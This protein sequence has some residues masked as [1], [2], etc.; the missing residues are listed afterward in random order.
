VLEGLGK[1]KKYFQHQEELFGN[2]FYTSR[3]P[4][5]NPREASGDITTLDDFYSAIKDCQK[6]A[7]SQTRT[8]LVFGAGNA[9]ANVM[10]IGEAPGRDEDLQGEPF[11]GKALAAVGFTREEVY[12][13]N[14]LKCRP[15]NNR[16]PNLEEIA[17]CIPY[18]IKQISLIQP[19]IILTLGRI[20]VQSLL[21]TSQ[22]LGRL[23]D[24]IHEFQGIAVI[25]TYHPA[26][27]LRNPHWKR[28]VWE[29]VQRL[30]HLYDEIVGDK[31]KWKPPKKV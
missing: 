15:P 13:G 16:D 8:N 30:R 17:L 11:V 7:L 29:D 24:E 20:A 28:P 22:S 25:T 27:L 14:I 19:K 1:I 10:L 2:E 18:V 23:R 26:A 3:S 31:E 12:I 9:N 6:C 4:V 5:F 21:K